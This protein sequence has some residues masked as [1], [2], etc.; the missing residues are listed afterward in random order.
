MGMNDVLMIDGVQFKSGDKVTCYIHGD[1]I[2]DAKIYITS[3]E[4]KTLDRPN[5]DAY[6]CQNIKNGW[7]STNPLGYTLGWAFGFQNSDT[8]RSFSINKLKKIKDPNILLNIVEYSF[9]KGK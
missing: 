8:L 2:K 4:E 9:P 6:I 3:T 7:N 5:I 1:F